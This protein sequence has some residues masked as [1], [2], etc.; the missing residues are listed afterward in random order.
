V[1]AADLDLNGNF[2]LVSAS[3]T[4]SI[5]SVFK[6]TNKHTFLPRQV[7]ATDGPSA[8]ILVADLNGDELPDVVSGG[9]AVT[10]LFNLGDGTLGAPVSI[11]G[12]PTSVRALAG[13]DMD[14]DGD[15]D[16]AVAHPNLAT[17][18]LNDGDG[19]FRSFGIHGVGATPT[20]IGIAFV[21]DDST[22][23]IVSANRGTNDASIVPG[24][25]D[26]RFQAESRV[27]VGKGPVDLALG[28]LNSDGQN[29]VV[30]ANRSAR[31]VTVL[32]NA[33]SP[34][35]RSCASFRESRTGRSGW[36]GASS[37]PRTARSLRSSARTRAASRRG[38]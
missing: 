25:G 16:V 1:R 27:K 31:S 4:Q 17:V 6:G 34:R 32:L 35:S 2:D 21:D 36:R 33:R 7:Y 22:L 9:S 26:G 30:T 38:R 28:D 12:G 19:Q 23:D 5:L 18:M 24:I 20:A 14:G 15:I 10:E 11:S 37:Q 13:E 3:S 29:D 8:A